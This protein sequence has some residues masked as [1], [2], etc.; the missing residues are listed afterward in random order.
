MV[1]RLEGKVQGQDIIFKHVQGD[2]WE[3]VIPKNLTGIYIIELTAYDDNGNTAFT[4]R[5]I[6][7][8]DLDAL[9]IHLE[10]YPFWTDVLP[11]KFCINILPEK[12][13]VRLC[14]G[15]DSI[16]NLKI[17]MDLGETRHV[18]LK[19]CSSVKD[20]FN[21]LDATYVLQKVGDQTPE[22]SGNCVIR[23]HIIDTVITPKES[24]AYIFRVT[25]TIADEILIDT[26]EV[27]VME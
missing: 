11:D 22:D 24:G 14:H 16:N 4:T 19:I 20:D 15:G 1:V 13:Y 25:Y 26:V 6:L 18:Q 23:E 9:C 10:P 2:D 8:V 12:Y 5:Y 3:A 27:K 21:I 17:V 7:T